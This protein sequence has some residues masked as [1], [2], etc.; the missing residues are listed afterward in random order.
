M[1]KVPSNR[2]DLCP[3]CRVWSEHKRI[4]VSDSIALSWCENCRVPRLARSALVEETRRPSAEPAE[5]PVAQGPAPSHPWRWFSLAA[6]SRI[7]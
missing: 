1:T 7:R 3:H 5:A 6:P 2:R 4:T